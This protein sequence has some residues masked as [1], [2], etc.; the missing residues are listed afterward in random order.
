MRQKLGLAI[1]ILV[2]LIAYLGLKPSFKKDTTKGQFTNG[3]KTMINKVVK[4][5]KEWK[6]ILTPD[7]YFVMRK[8]G[9]EVAFS[10]KYNDHDEKG[11]YVC[12][13]CRTP[14]F[15]SE[16][17]YDHG[18]GWPSFT[19]PV[20]KTHID[21][22]DD[23]SH[24]MHRTETRCAVCGAHLGHVFNDGP[25]PTGEHYCINSVSLDF[26]PAVASQKTESNTGKKSDEQDTK[27]LKTE[28]A[29]F[30]AGCFWGVEH[31][32]RQV[33]GVIS[34]VVGYTGGNVKNPT[35]KQV[36]SDKTGHAEAV[37][38]TFDP[39]QLSYEKLLETF[40]DL[41][42]PTQVNRQGWDVGS[43]YRSA[44]F[45]HNTEQKETAEKM[46]KKLRSSG[47]LKKDVATQIV[48]APEF[49]EAEEYH[50]QYYDKRK[51][52]ARAACG[53]RSCSIKQD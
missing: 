43:Q 47:R 50:Q 40:F 46:V 13:G 51:K 53:T 29:T 39:S 20:D 36:C 6:K 31:R 15:S 32:F 21:Y 22:F 44:I 33:P 24:F 45:Y 10:G 28:T 30:A 19:A 3:E 18:T 25:G 38:I 26:K 27:S 7:Q 23:F 16:T 52:D 34:T 5:D 9:T 4:S 37:K 2:V 8:R 1:T 14:L 35:Y 11:T 41:H 42:D 12:A 49:Y 48:P 17:K